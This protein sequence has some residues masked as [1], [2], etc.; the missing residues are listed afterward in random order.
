M[1]VLNIT[2][3]LGSGA[4][5]LVLEAM[6]R[7]IRVAT[8]IGRDS[9]LRS[10]RR[11]ATEQMR[12]PTNAELGDALERLPGGD[13]LGPRY[14]AR[15][16]LDARTQLAEFEPDL[17]FRFWR[18]YRR[19][20]EDIGSPGLVSR[21][22]DLGYDRAFSTSGFP[23]SSG[24]PLGLEII[25]PVLYHALVALRTASLAPGEIVVRRL[26]YSN[27]FGEE[28]VAVGAAAEA[29][30]KTAGVIETAATI[31]SRRAIKRTERKVAEA[32][33]DEKIRQEQERTRRAELE[34]D[35]LEQDLIA[36]QIQNAQAL[37]ALDVQ[38]Q[39]RALVDHFI[40]AG[41][42]DQA[43][44]IEAADP[45]EAAALLALAARRPQLERGQEPDPEDTD[46]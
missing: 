1:Q 16:Q 12:F 37:A 42:L 9:E 10:V 15:R 26:E 34:N 13:E 22:S 43:D 41:E 5:P 6:V 24:G 11:T 25:D 2:L 30:K 28:L 4:S 39:Q 27:P 17:P 7:G 21:L 38:R 18:D 14:R 44:A 20:L 45:A 36:K 32:T 19:Y 40:A 8:D 46:E 35:L 31:G 23:W 29:L 3:D 33:V